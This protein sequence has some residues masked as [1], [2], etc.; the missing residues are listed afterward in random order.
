MSRRCTPPIPNLAT[1]VLVAKNGLLCNHHTEPRAY[2]LAS[3]STE[4][5]GEVYDQ[6]DRHSTRN[7]FPLFVK[8]S[9]DLHVIVASDPGM[10]AA[11][12][13]DTT[14]SAHVCTSSTYTSM[15]S[16]DRKE[17]TNKQLLVLNRGGT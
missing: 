17:I 16:P 10:L 1:N 15:T 6:V 13:R 12:P 9:H 2:S 3:R 8:Y 5:A 4:R 11:L 14:T 7:S